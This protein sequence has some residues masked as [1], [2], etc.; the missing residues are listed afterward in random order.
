MEFEFKIRSINED[1]QKILDRWKYQSENSLISDIRDG[2]L[3][4]AEMD[5]ILLRQL[6]FDRNELQNK[7]NKIQ[8]Y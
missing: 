7:K 5:A 4:N 8:E 2:I 1:I 6:I 3:K